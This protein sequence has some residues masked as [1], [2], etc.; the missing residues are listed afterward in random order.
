MKVVCVG[1]DPAALYLG[2]LLKRKDPIPQRPLCRDRRRHDVASLLDRLQSAQ[3]AAEARR[4]RGARC[5]ERG[6]RHVRSRRGQHRRAHVRDAGLAYASVR[7]AGLVDALKRI[8]TD[9]GCEFHYCAARCDPRRARWRRSDR[10]RRRAASADP[11]APAERGDARRKSFLAFESA[12]PRNALGL[13]FPH[14]AGRR[15]ARRHMAASGGSTVAVEAPAN[16]IRANGLDQ[17]SP[18]RCSHSAASILPT[19]STACRRPA[20]ACGNRS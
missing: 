2:I 14:H 16:V 6:G 3:A 17:T 10:R 8:A 12:K 20:I 15:D 9:A 13:R 4:C 18:K 5:R 11:D 19:H 1:A 7:T